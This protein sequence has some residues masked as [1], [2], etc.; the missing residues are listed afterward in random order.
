MS[1][2]IIYCLVI[3]FIYVLYYTGIIYVDARMKGKKKDGETEEISLDG[4]LPGGNIDVQ[5]VSEDGD[6]FNIKPE[7][8]IENEE[9]TDSEANGYGSDFF[10]VENED[11]T[12]NGNEQSD[13][14]S[15]NE[16]EQ[17]PFDYASGTEAEKM[18]DAPSEDPSLLNDNS[19]ENQSEEDEATYHNV[20]SNTE[21][22]N[23]TDG[24]F[25]EPESELEMPDGLNQSQRMIEDI[26]GYMEKIP[27]T[28]NSEFTQ[29]QMKTELVNGSDK[30]A[31]LEH[32]EVEE[33]I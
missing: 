26:I 30:V 31:I 18:Y 5:D 17:E 4:E 8:D 10:P 9:K 2:F 1:Y 14:S 29:D 23:S 12:G 13:L 20:D 15:E 27:K 3:T 22:E 19:N 16:A 21:S 11:P 24:N 28:I 32:E 33:R 6:G 25:D 7:N